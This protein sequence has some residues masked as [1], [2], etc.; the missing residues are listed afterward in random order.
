MYKLLMSVYKEFLLLKRDP[1]G[2]IILFVMPLVLIITV[3][4]IQDS[5]FK[6]ATE[7]KIPILVVDNDKGELSDVINGSL[8]NN[9]AFEVITKSEGKPIDEAFARDNVFNG[10]YQLAI[11]I[12]SGLSKGLKNRVDSNV[13]KI[14]GNLGAIEQPEPQPV[15]D[16]LQLKEVRVYFD[17]V[18]QTAFKNAVKSTIDKMISQIETKSIYDAFGKQLGEESTGAFQQEDY[19]TFKEI[20]PMFEN[21]EMIPNSTQHNVPAWSLFAIFFI[22]VPLS[23]NIVK[24]KKQGTR[25]RFRTNPVPYATV[26]AGKTITYLFICVIQFFLMVVVGYYLFPQVGLPRLDMHGSF[27][28]MSLVAVFA[29]FAAVGF[30]ILLGTMSK[31]QEQAAPFGSTSVVILAAI[32]GVWVPVFAMPGIMQY[33]AKASPMNWALEAFYD[34]LLRNGTLLDILPQLGML[35]LFYM[36]M[37]LIALFYDEKKRAV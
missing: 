6:T 17:P 24:E 33:I 9:S 22:V 27:W 25:V 28:L 35:F 14:L 34:V 21:R 37:I 29:G 12:P 19:I 4:P 11:I 20:I 2:L 18:S 16:S 32:G 8:K 13:Y 7:T 3:T 15:E 10:N 31:T 30:G 36:V 5:S 1:G 23:I 26:I